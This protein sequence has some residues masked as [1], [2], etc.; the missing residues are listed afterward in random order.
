MGQRPQPSETINR[1]LT[2][3]ADVL[4]SSFLLAP[5]R[6]SRLGHI[7]AVSFQPTLA[8]PLRSWGHIKDIEWQF[9]DQRGTCSTAY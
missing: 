7:Y 4:G 6:F 2:Q 1:D 5:R 9:C 3:L 8:L